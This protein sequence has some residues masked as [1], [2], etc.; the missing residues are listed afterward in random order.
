MEWI[1]GRSDA[2][3]LMYAV[4]LVDARHSDWD[5]WVPAIELVQCGRVVKPAV[6]LKVGHYEYNAWSERVLLDAVRW[7][8]HPPKPCVVFRMSM[9]FRD[10]Q[11]GRL[12]VAARGQVTDTTVAM[13]QYS[14]QLVCAALF[15]PTLR[16]HIDR[17]TALVEAPGPLVVFFVEEDGT[18]MNHIFCH[19]ITGGALTQLQDASL[20][21]A[22]LPPPD[23]AAFDDACAAA[24]AD[25]PTKNWWS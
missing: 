2:P 22:K 21:A 15:D 9:F 8:W 11:G 14:H 12:G 18:R 5:L 10:P 16:D 24:E 20:E 7:E 25:K 23:R 1:L 3:D 17:I 19:G 4:D 13:D 6:F